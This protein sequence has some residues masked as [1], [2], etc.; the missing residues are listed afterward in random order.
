[1][2][3]R[4]KAAAEARLTIRLTA[5]QL[6][7]LKARAEASR[8]TVTE[9]ARLVLVAEEGVLL[10]RLTDRARRRFEQSAERAGRSLS[11]HLES[12]LLGKLGAE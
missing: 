10:L 1:M 7:L 5:E 6:E 8:L 3:P 11:W 4:G 12:L 2:D 9:Y